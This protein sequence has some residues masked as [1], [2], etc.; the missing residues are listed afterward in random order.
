L[1]MSESHL[2]HGQVEHEGCGKLATNLATT[3]LL[4]DN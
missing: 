4:S 1:L 2:A 3:L